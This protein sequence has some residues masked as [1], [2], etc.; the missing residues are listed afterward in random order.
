MNSTALYRTYRPQTFKDV[1]GQEHVTEVLEAAIKKGQIAHAY[2]FSGSRGTGKTSMARIFAREIGCTDKDLYEIDA[3]S[4]NSVDDIREL[5]EGVYVVPFESPYKV[6]IVDEAHM[7][8]KS[9]WNAFLKTLEEPPA[10]AIFILAT[11]ELNKVPATIQSRCDV[12][13]FKQPTRELLAKTVTA[14]AKK[15]GYT[16]ERA[17]AELI[18]LLA[19]G[20]F[21]D[22]LGILQKVLTV[23]KDKK[24]DISEV[25]R[26]TGAPQAEQVRALVSALAASDSATALQLVHKAVDGNVDMRMYSKLLLERI[27]AVLILRHAPDMRPVLEESLSPD[28]ITLAEGLTK[29][30]GITSNTLRALL[31][32]QSLMAYAALPHLPLELAIIDICV[33]RR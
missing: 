16:L 24:V 26:V 32:A 12:Y 5:R 17:S 1:Q 28:D 20:A 23:S 2:L 13:T 14:V 15:E 25:E 19:E 10:H 22:A 11:T 30:K 33:E 6:Y 8:S 31:D 27:R 18:A 3:A 9:A 4:N 7:L 21:R 29:E